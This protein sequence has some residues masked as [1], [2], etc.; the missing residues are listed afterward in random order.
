MEPPAHPFTSEL[1]NLDL[2]RID[3]RPCLE[4]QRDLVQKRQRGEVPDL[5]LFV[6][7]PPTYTIGSNRPSN[8]LLVSL[9]E[10]EAIGAELVATDRGGDITFHGPGQIVGYP[11]FDLSGW[12]KD[13]HAYLRALEEVLIRAMRPFGIASERVSGRTGVWHR[14]EK[15]A[16][17]GIRVSR[18]VSSH[19]FALNVSTRL[20]DFK[21]IVPC[22]IV[23]SKVGSMETTLN[24]PVDSSAVRGE[25]ARQF[26]RVFGRRPLSPVA[27][28]RSVDSVGAVVP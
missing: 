12:N 22:G 8:H 20:D 3:Y 4:L 26:A 24:A 28:P 23:G 15:L 27:R 5:L 9:E 7:H 1:L 6:E 14:G 19:G 17:I 21:R 18:W 2:G 13:V 11:I 16:A 25:I 10:L